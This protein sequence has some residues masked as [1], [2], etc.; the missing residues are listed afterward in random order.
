LEAAFEA[1]RAAGAAG[2][3]V[4][5]MAVDHDSVDS[6]AMRARAVGVAAGEVA[7]RGIVVGSQVVGVG[8]EVVTTQ[9]DRRLLTSRRSWV[10]NG[11]R[12]VV[13]RSSPTAP[14]SRMVGGAGYGFRPTT[15]RST[16]CWRTPSLSTRPRA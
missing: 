14:S 6:L 10:R 15:P 9:N 4:V 13:G 11:D 3:S 2:E 5:V 12:W 8:D 16:S 7:A 1:W